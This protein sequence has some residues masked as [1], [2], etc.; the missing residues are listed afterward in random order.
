MNYEI[1]KHRTCRKRLHFFCSVAPYRLVGKLVTFYQSRLCSI[2]SSTAVKTSHNANGT[3]C[4]V[5]W[6]KFYTLLQYTP[7]R[8][9]DVSAWM[10]RIVTD[11]VR[12]DAVPVC[13]S[14]L[15]LSPRLLSD[16]LEGR[17][18]NWPSLRQQTV[19][20]I[21]LMISKG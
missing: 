6:I 21:S 15:P 20:V 10:Q 19:G 9:G 17:S 11:N 3:L 16:C 4:F 1:F 5:S 8:I 12:T 14:S 18:R 2:F 13:V 7:L